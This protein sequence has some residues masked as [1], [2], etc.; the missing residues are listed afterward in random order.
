MPLSAPLR[1]I[2]LFFFSF[3]L[4]NVW[5]CFAVPQVPEPLRCPGASLCSAAALT[6]CRCWPPFPASPGRAEAAAAALCCCWLSC[7]C[8]CLA[9]ARP[10]VLLC[11][12][13]Q[14][15]QGKRLPP[16]WE[17]LSHFVSYFSLKVTLIVGVYCMPSA[18]DPAKKYLS[19]S[20]HF[21]K[22][23]NWINFLSQSIINWWSS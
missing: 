1:S 8:S 18:T 12:F 5:N 3:F 15:S 19:L 21:F 22:W 11:L 13:C 23:T 7:R 20:Q 17:C 16:G 10:E 14:L 2:R 4:L 6:P 9:F